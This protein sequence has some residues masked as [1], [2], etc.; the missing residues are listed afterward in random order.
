MFDGLLQTVLSRFPEINA[1]GLDNG[2]KTFWIMKQIFDSGRIAVTTYRRPMTQDG[3][4]KKCEYV[5]VEYCDSMLCP[6]DQVLE[7][8]TTNREGYREYE[9]DPVICQNYPSERVFAYAKKKAL[10]A[11]HM[12]SRACKVKDANLAYFLLP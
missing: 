4:F 12:L 2:Y 11:L 6:E 8:S 5:Y 1:M 9:S 10:H 3:L 7:Y